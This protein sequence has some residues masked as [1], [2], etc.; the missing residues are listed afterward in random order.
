MQ[1]HIDYVKDLVTLNLE[2]GPFLTGGLMTW[3]LEVQCHKQIPN[4][5]PDDLDICCV[6]EDQFQYVKRILQPMA[7]A[8]K[9]TNW[10]GHSGTYWTINDFRYQAFVHPVSVQERLNIVDYTVTSIASDGTNFITGKYTM[11]D[12]ANRII[13]LNDNIYEW[14]VES[15]M[16]RYKKYVSRGYVDLDNTTLNRLNKIYET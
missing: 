6:S 9:G 15:I 11:D 10:L 12:I 1:K 8:T 5:L 2:T 14:P 3:Q 4:W 16:G 13:R 7:I